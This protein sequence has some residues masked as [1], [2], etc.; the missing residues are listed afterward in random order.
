MSEVRGCVREGLRLEVY[1][2]PPC[3]LVD[4]HD[5]VLLQWSWWDRLPEPRRSLNDT[6]R[7]GL[8]YV[9]L[10][11]ALENFIWKGS[12]VLIDI[13]YCFQLAIK[14][15]EDKDHDFHLSELLPHLQPTAVSTTLLTTL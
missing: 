2:R 12:F 7:S 1:G 13:T 11:L 8:D 4:G 14:F 15:P 3:V 6:T 10:S 9:L 5:H